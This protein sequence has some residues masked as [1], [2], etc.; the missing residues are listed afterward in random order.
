M[1]QPCTPKHVTAAKAA[2]TTSAFAQGLGVAKDEA[3]AVALYTKA[4]NEGADS[5]CVYLGTL[6][7]RGSMVGKDEARAAALFTKACDGGNPL[8]CRRLG[9]L[10]LWPFTPRHATGVKLRTAAS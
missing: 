4:C 10:A 2:V 5:S 1:P 3:R 6:F 7:E 9:N 8:G